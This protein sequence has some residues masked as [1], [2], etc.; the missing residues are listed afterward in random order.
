MH[1]FSPKATLKDRP[2]S[3]L[4]AG[5]GRRRSHNL[6]LKLS[7]DAQG[8]WAAHQSAWSSGSR[9]S[10][11]A[12]HA[13]AIP[14]FAHDF[15]MMPPSVAETDAVQPKLVIDTPGDRFEKEA[16]QVADKIMALAQDP[17]APEELGRGHAPEAPFQMRPIPLMPGNNSLGGGGQAVPNPAR[18]RLEQGFGYDFSAVR[19]HTDQTAAQSA[20]GLQARAYTT[21][22]HI[23][24]STGQF[25]PHTSA[26]MRLLAHE[27]AHVVQQSQAGSALTASSQG[28]Y[29]PPSPAAPALRA[30]LGIQ[31]QC[32]PTNR[33]P[34]NLP[35]E[36]IEDDYQARINPVSATEYAIP[37]S[38]PTGG[39]GYADIADLALHHIYEIKTYPGG[40]QGV[41]EAARYAAQAT[42]HCGTP[43]DWF[44]GLLYPDSVIPVNS[45]TELVAKQYLGV[46]PG[47]PTWPGVVVYY[48]RRRRRRRVPQPVRIPVWVIVLLF[49]LFLI[50]LAIALLEPTPAGELIWAAA[51]ILVLLNLGVIGGDDGSTVAA[52][53][54]DIPP[55]P[56]EVAAGGDLEAGLRGLITD[57]IDLIARMPS[58]VEGD[59]SEADVRRVKQMGEAAYARIQ[60]ADPDDPLLAGVNSALE[61]LLPYV[62]Q[63]ETMARARRWIS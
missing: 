4:F 40:P 53:S 29:G 7:P 48:T 19:I 35:H 63:A 33:Y 36:L 8:A 17:G 15:S 5:L 32:F 37:G 51:L 22:S 23:A 13:P 52:L 12:P 39:T 34:G 60:R 59:F 41:I 38:G 56:T 62:R 61:G 57:N 3:K 10:M 42:I 43:P 20:A 9:A 30:P 21:G 49:L 2:H 27:L 16:D 11:H 31:R 44:P 6:R 18:S 45:T 24:F 26:G 28:G 46:G 54:P 1:R 47:H 14:G 25:A 55:P 50:A 58:A